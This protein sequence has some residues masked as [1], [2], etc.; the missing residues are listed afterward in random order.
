[1]ITTS[2][3]NSKFDAI[4]MNDD[5]LNGDI[6]ANDGIFSTS[7][8]FPGNT[9]VKFYIRAENNEAMMFSPER[10]EYE[11][12]EYSTISGF[13]NIEYFSDKRLI[14]VCDILGRKVNPDFNVPL[15]FIYDD[16][17]VEKKIMIRQ[18]E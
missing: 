12:Y 9:E 14:R 6:Q 11:F 7:I 10:A 3:Y 4:S 16:G 1:M 18:S 15:F 8:P 13:N 5:G 2:Q 17:T